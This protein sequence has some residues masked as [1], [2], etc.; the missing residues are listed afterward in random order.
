MVIKNRSKTKLQ[1]IRRDVFLYRKDYESLLITLEPQMILP[2]TTSLNSTLD[3]DDNSVA[4]LF[5]GKQL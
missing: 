1:E 2:I 4:R 5:P 3:H